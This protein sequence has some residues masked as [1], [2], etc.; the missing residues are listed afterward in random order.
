MEVCP[1]ISYGS[2]EKSFSIEKTMNEYADVVLQDVTTGDDGYEYD[3]VLFSK[4]HCYSESHMDKGYDA[5]RHLVMTLRK[6]HELKMISNKLKMELTSC[7]SQMNILRA[8]NSYI[9]TENI[10][11]KNAMKVGAT[12]STVNSSA[13]DISFMNEDYATMSRELQQL[14]EDCG[15]FNKFVY[16]ELDLIKTKIG[17][18][19]SNMPSCN[20]STSSTSTNTT[21][22]VSFQLV[23]EHVDVLPS[24]AGMFSSASSLGSNR[25]GNQ[26]SKADERCT[27]NPKI[28]PGTKS[29]SHAHIAE[30]V[31]LCD[32]TIGY[33]TSKQF[34]CYLEGKEEK[35]ILKKFPGHTADEIKWYC[36]HPLGHIKPRQVIVIAGTN[37]ITKGFYENDLNV[38]K[39]INNIIDIGRKGKENGAVNVVISSILPRRGH[40]YVEV[41]REINK[42]LSEACMDEGFTFLDNM[43]IVL[44]HIGKD[45]IHPNNQGHTILKM[46]LLKCMITF[47]PYCCDFTSFYE[48]CLL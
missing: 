11:L 45:G 32:S 36:D 47:N 12:E 21:S 44:S 26:A 30:T 22:D 16:Q 19:N 15:R 24:P 42:G 40:K 4:R 14:R 38:N 27:T 17:S 7:K 25:D 31:V 33:T 39:I 1:G 18:S 35:I 20:T 41:I 43:D 10:R 37:D 34:N 29:Y 13:T 8:D 2:D 9:R 5:E 46:N 48:K 6:L 28:V 23:D 3:E